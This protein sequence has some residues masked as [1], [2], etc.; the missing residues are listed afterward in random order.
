M[1]ES[2]P[3]PE[4]VGVPRLRTARP[5]DADEVAR[6]AELMYRSLGIELAPGVWERWRSSAARA[7]RSRLGVELTAVVAEDPDGP[8]RLVAC[9]AGAIS[10]RLPN[11]SHGDPRVGY[12]QWMSTEPAWRS[13]GLGRAV[14]RALLDWFESQGVDN[15]ELHA[16]VSGASLYRSEG[17][18][19]GSTGIAMRRRSWDPPPVT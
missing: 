13:R 12:V 9:G 3:A 14:L 16:S 19:E 10:E 6:L 18:W 15:V 1:S 17:F 11:P 7:V 5:A 4:S 8:A 2:E